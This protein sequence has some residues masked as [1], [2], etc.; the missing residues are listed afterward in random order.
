MFLKN[1]QNSLENTCS[2]DFLFNK[3]AVLWNLQNFLGICFYRT[4][5]GL[6]LLP[7][8]NGKIIFINIFKNFG[9]KQLIISSIKLFSLSAHSSFR[10]KFKNFYLF[11]LSPIFFSVSY[12]QTSCSTWKIN[13][14]TVE[15]RQIFAIALKEKDCLRKQ[16]CIKEICQI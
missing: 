13:K 4:L 11:I 9:L 8:I 1:S 2:R 14:Y 10:N 6:F 7:E 16:R 3:V 5:R 12:H 15:P